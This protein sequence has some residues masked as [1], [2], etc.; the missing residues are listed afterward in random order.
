MEAIHL[1]KSILILSI[2]MLIVIAS[3]TC[4]S[5]G[6]DKIPADLDSEKLEHMGIKLEEPTDMSAFTEDSE[7]IAILAAQK[8]TNSIGE[9]KENI[10]VKRCLI[11]NPSMQLFSEAALEKNPKLKAKGYMDKLPVYIIS[12]KTEASYGF[13]LDSPKR[14]P[15]TEG[16]V[17]IDALS[18]EVLMSFSYN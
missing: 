4:V 11:T 16:H 5:A 15:F 9:S 12:F 18:G 1:K 6:I 10:K 2:M 13:G 14:K 8:E 7:K 17:V 3:T